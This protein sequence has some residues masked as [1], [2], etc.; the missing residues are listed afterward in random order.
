MLD[1]GVVPGGADYCEDQPAEPV[2]KDGVDGNEKTTGCQPRAEEGVL[3]SIQGFLLLIHLII[4]L[5]PFL[6]RHALQLF[7]LGP[8]IRRVH[9]EDVLL[10]G[11]PLL[12]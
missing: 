8:A 11:Q 6:V 9:E 3:S 12:R 1:A 5:A 4:P 10:A 2:V 7:T